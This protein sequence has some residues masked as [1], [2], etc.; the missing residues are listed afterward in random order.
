MCPRTLQ[1][2]NMSNQKQSAG[3]NKWS[4]NKIMEAYSDLL[5]T[6]GERPK[7]TYLFTKKLGI[8]E[9]DLYRFFS[10]LDHLEQEYLVHFFQETLKLTQK[11]EGYAELSPKEKL[12]NLY[13]LFFENLALNRSLIYVLLKTDVRYRFNNLKA[14]RST[15]QTYLKTLNLK[16]E[17][18]FSKAP[19]QLKALSQYPK[20]E[21]LW[22]HLL[23]ILKFWL[24][25][26]SPNFE[27]T[28]AYIE[29]S[30]SLGWEI[31]ETSFTS[32]LLDFGRF[33]WQEKFE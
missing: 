33:L 24:D 32:K 9:A 31:M 4:K 15:Y 2:Q 21:V 16:N 20:E 12:L 6:T 8:E 29:K 23:S 5:L 27:K 14:L 17:E 3:K 11:T 25:D 7:T 26:R 13:Y 18:L 30:M 19:E 10:D 22:L 1:N 28:D